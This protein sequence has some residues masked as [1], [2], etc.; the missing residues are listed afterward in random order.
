MQQGAI[1]VVCRKQRL[2]VIRR[3]R[4]VVAPGTYCFPGGA[5]EL[6]E[7][8]SQALQREFHE[9]LGARLLPVQRIWQSV[10]PWNIR[11]S[12]WLADLEPT[13]VLH[14]NLQEVESIHWLTMEEIRALPELLTSNH[15][16]LAAWDRREFS[17]PIE[18]G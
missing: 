1:A 18:E 7:S 5:I 15:A 12:W 13:A 3:S 9:E 16:F 2:L 17:L 10:T 8:E 6:G 11:L 4:F 14:P